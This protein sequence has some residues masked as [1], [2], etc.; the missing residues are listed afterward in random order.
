[1]GVRRYR[2]PTVSW[3]VYLFATWNRGDEKKREVGDGDDAREPTEATLAP[4]EDEPNGQ[5]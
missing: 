4:W 5:R 1:M 3:S 2:V